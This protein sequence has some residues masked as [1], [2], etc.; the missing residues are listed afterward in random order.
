MVDYCDGWVGEQQPFHTKKVK[1]VKR[2]RFHTYRCPHKDPE[3]DIPCGWT[4]EIHESEFQSDQDAQ[5][6]SL[7]CPKCATLATYLATGEESHCP[8]CSEGV[9]AA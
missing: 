7:N 3:T 9:V 4:V 2:A 5:A 6:Y 8:L 1:L